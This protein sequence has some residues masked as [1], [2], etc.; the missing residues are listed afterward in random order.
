MVS[1]FIKSSLAGKFA[2]MYSVKHPLIFLRMDQPFM[3]FSSDRLIRIKNVM[4]DV[5][6]ELRD[7]RIDWR[8][9]KVSSSRKISVKISYDL[10]GV[11]QPIESF[12]YLPYDVSLTPTEANAFVRDIKDIIVKIRLRT[13]GQ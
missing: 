4:L 13:K 10:D 12:K 11:I 7:F 3:Y 6:R 1:Y 8:T 5:I 2:V 9:F